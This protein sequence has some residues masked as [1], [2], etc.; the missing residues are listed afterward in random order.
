MI[1]LDLP[2]KAGFDWLPDRE[3]SHR[4][5][6]NGYIRAYQHEMLITTTCLENNALHYS[7]KEKIRNS[8]QTSEI[9]LSSE[10]LFEDVAHWPL[11]SIMVSVYRDGNR[12]S[13]EFLSG[14]VRTSP[15]YIAWT[16]ERV[17]ASWDIT[18]L[19]T[20]ETMADL[21]V[22]VL[23]AEIALENSYT[24]KTIFRN[25]IR[26]MER[27]H[28]RADA[29]GISI[30]EPNPAPVFTPRKLAANADPGNAYARLLQAALVRPAWSPDRTAFEL[31]GGLDST[32][33]VA[34]SS[35]SEMPAR[36]TSGTLL[37]G[38]IGKQQRNRRNEVRSLL[39]SS[40]DVTV[41]GAEALCSLSLNQA[42][43]PIPFE[44]PNSPVGSILLK[45]LRGRG[46]TTIVTGIGGDELFSL[47]PWEQETSSLAQPKSIP[48]LNHSPGRDSCFISAEDTSPFP[49]I[50]AS[51]L[52]AACNRAPMFMRAGVWLVNPLCSPELTQFA[53]QLPLEWRADR[54]LLRELLAK[55][56]LTSFSKPYPSETYDQLNIINIK[57]HQRDIRLLFQQS[58][59]ADLNIIDRAELES[60]FEKW[61]LG[62][63]SLAYDYF[64]ALMTLEL[65]LQK[66]ACNRS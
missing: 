23:C 42:F 36:F 16:P 14:T 15:L 19:C 61:I 57:Q 18:A 60:C 17:R 7:V 43:S 55:M 20:E 24:P 38:E 5:G 3:G 28:V 44:N 59:L 9:P 2:F 25:V 64:H 45:E 47:H 58:R 1:N 54:R 37:P 41:E 27:M 6:A 46:I 63:R 66:G 11:D 10:Q 34:I 35:T 33:L 26:L 48:Y 49:S 12:L 30:R 65:F 62:E 51:S 52:L 4:L 40:K 21:N 32:S 39:K 22:P 8:P 13:V 29:N 50:A 56:G 31:S 53:Q